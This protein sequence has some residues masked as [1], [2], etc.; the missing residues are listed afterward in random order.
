MPSSFSLYSWNVNGIRAAQKKGFLNWVRKQ[1]PDILCLQEIKAQESDLTQDLKEIAGYESIWE[2]GPRKGY[3]GVAIYTKIKPQQIIKNLGEAILD[4]EG[5]VLTVNF[6]Q[7]T[8]FNI[9]FPYDKRSPE[10]LAYKMEFY[11]RFLNYVKSLKIRNSKLEIIVCGDVNTAHQEIDLARPA[12]NAQISGF[13]PEER[14]WIDE[15]LAAGFVDSFRYLHPKEIAYSW[16]SQRTRARER[17]VG[18]R[19]D[20]FFVSE[21]L[22]A[23][24]LDAQIHSEI[25]GSDH[26]PVSVELQL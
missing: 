22:Q 19:I 7:F 20:Y 6:D 15:L 8:L 4:E 18:W 9:Y 21:N 25:A 16:W 3:G 23:S 13:L 12:E 11:R 10:R 1:E 5:R 2:A 26:C 24:L 17:N 14:V